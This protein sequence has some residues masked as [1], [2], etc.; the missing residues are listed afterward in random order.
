MLKKIKEFLF[1]NNTTSQTIVK[2][3][4]WLSFGQIFSRLIRSFIIIYSARILGA[5]EFGVFSY[6]MGLAG[7][8]TVFSDIGVNPIMIRE[9]SQKP[10]ST[11]SYVATSFWI[12]LTLLSIASILIIF[13]APFFAKSQLT[14]PLILLVA[15]LVFFDSMREFATSVL[16]IKER[17]DMEAFVTIVTNVSIVALGF[18]ALLYSSTAKSFTVSYSFGVGIGTL[19]SFYVARK[20][21]ASIFKSFK[22]NLVRP[23]L[24]SSIPVALLSMFG[25]F[26]LNTDIVMIGF[27]RTL[28][29]IGLYSAS[30]KILLFLYML[31][32]VVIMTIFPALS[33][34]I[35]Q[36]NKEK[37]RMLIEK[38]VTSSLLIAVPISIGGVILSR[39]I[40]LFL[41]GA[42]YLPTVPVFTILI[43]TIVLAFPGLAVSN[44]ML[45]Y[46][47]QKKLAPYIILGALSN[48]I[49]DALL[50][51]KYGIVGSAFATLGA[52]L[53]YDSSAWIMAKKLNNFFTL[54][55]LK[56]IFI[57]GAFMAIGT[58]IFK[59]IGMNLILNIALSSIIYIGILIILKE[60]LFEDIKIAI[61]SPQ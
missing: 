52:H 36:G 54:R 44:Y 39:E 14:A 41:Y 23:I 30:Q 59:S 11:S 8:F 18:V 61:R 48:I 32:A 5:S 28:E 10:E 31:P 27:W 15:L 25:T 53:I 58:F 42:S 19:I 12:K 2:N 49:F 22:K 38:T 16:R 45:A 47:A 40:I 4:F 7:F 17:M 33:R 20:Q 1:H 37:I 43:I 3:V 29:E 9:S 26:M 56:S 60:K 13:V 46:N 50:I 51:P 55:Y 21:L 57:A 34:F 6:I 35:G 24:F